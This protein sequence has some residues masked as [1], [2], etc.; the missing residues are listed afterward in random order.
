MQQPQGQQPGHK[1]LPSGQQEARAQYKKRRGQAGRV[2]SAA[3]ASAPAMDLVAY[4]Q[5]QPGDAGTLA[6][7]IILRPCAVGALEAQTAGTGAS[8]VDSEE[9]VLVAPRTT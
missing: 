8:A 7:G 2:L 4:L 6:L 3:Y 9:D 1:P 5:W